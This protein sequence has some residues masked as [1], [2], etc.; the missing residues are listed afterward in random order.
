VVAD[1]ERLGEPPEGLSGPLRAIPVPDATIRHLRLSEQLTG[2]FRPSARIGQLDCQKKGL[3]GRFKTQRGSQNAILVD[4]GHILQLQHS[5]QSPLL[6]LVTCLLSEVSGYALTGRQ[7]PFSPASGRAMSSG[8][9]GAVACPGPL[10]P[11]RAVGPGQAGGTR[12]T[13]LISD[14]AF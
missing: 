6:A 14:A 7:T 11:K 10:S 3:G 8:V 12:A 13:R 1:Q 5:S 2:P 4:I 9:C